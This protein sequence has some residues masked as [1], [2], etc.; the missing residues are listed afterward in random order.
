MDI[1]DEFVKEVSA[2]TKIDTYKGNF[3]FNILEVLSELDEESKK[4]LLKD[5]GWWSF[6]SEAMAESIVNEFSREHY[7]A[8]YTKLRQMILNSESMPKLIKEWAVSVFESMEDAKEN[9][10]YWDRAYWSLYS[11]T[12]EKIDFNDFWQNAPKLPQRYYNKEY[13]KEL[14]KDVK[15]KVEEWAK[16]FPELENYNIE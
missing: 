11:W 5:G 2:T 15:N 1:D 4:Q 13:S 3:S 14:M 6:V 16:L 12:R 8:E 7:N 9:K 10:D